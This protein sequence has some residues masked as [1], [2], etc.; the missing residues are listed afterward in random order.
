MRAAPL[1]DASA[2]LWL[3]SMRHASVATIVLTAL[4]LSVGVAAGQAVESGATP[5]TTPL[6]WAAKHGQTEI[7]RML[8]DAGASPN[9]RDASR[10]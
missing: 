7:A 1:S 8:L 3:N 5:F 10:C 2:G 6:H 9:S 4:L